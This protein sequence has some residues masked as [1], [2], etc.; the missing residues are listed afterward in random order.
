MDYTILGRT[1]LRVSVAGL[2]CGGPSRLGLKQNGE[3]AAVALVRQAMDLGVSFLDTA[4]WYGT[5]PVVGAAIAEVPRDRLI[6]STKKTIPPLDHPDIEG[7]IRKSFEQSLKQ[8]RTDYVDVYHVHGV[9]PGQ[10]RDVKERLL[11]GFLKLRRQGKIR[12]IGITERF[13]DDPTHKVL[14]QALEDNCWDVV[15]IGFNF[16]N[17]CARNVFRLTQTQGVG[18]INMYAVRRGLSQPARWKAICADLAKNGIAA[19]QSLNSDDPLD[20]LVHDGG[21]STV[22]E[23]AYRFC[24][25]EPGV[26]VVLTGTGNPDHLKANVEAITKPPLPEAVSKRL[27]EIFG[28]VDWVSGN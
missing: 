5:E 8:L 20:F 18:V 28:N 25:H 13:P 11:P 4:E 24:R 14:L 7:E 16:L 6:I 2:G 15:M 9:F 1:G 22:P 23:A 10:Y 27:A 19:A 3:K 26:H 12:S 21:A 17:P